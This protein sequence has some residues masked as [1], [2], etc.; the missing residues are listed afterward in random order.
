MMGRWTIVQLQS[1]SRSYRW[2]APYVSFLAM[3]GIVYAYRGLPVL[4]SYAVTSVIVYVFAVW[5]TMLVWTMEQTSERHIVQTHVA[6]K[7]TYWY[8]KGAA[9]FLIVC[10]LIALALVVPL[11]AGNFRETGPLHWYALA[12]TSH[13][14]LAWCGVVVGTACY[15][16]GLATKKYTA[17][18]ALGLIVYSLSFD[19][20]IE[21]YPFVAI[22]SWVTPPLFRVLRYLTEGESIVWTSW[23]VDGWFIGCFFVISF[24]V[25]R[26]AFHRYES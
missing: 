26:Y 10:P 13:V 21:T 22:T 8:G 11:L 15:G 16:T 12:S 1:F 17:L 2:V 9:S 4:S 3:L 19:V 25:L 20:L 14:V 7:R 6:S 23:I 18:V 24:Y 5:L